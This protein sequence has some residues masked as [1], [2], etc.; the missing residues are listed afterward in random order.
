MQNYNKLSQSQFDYSIQT[1]KNYPRLIVLFLY[2]TFLEVRHLHLH[3]LEPRGWV[4]YPSHLLL[5]QFYDLLSNE[6]QEKKFS[7]VHSLFRSISLRRYFQCFFLGERKQAPKRR[8]ALDMHTRWGKANSAQQV[9]HITDYTLLNSLASCF[10][11]HHKFFAWLT[12]LLTLWPCVA[13]LI[14]WS[15]NWVESDAVCNHTSKH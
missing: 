2:G 4:L 15:W 6:Q 8:G 7:T 11:T 1:I 9:Q 10:A 14:I 12:Y 5:L 3:L 13:L